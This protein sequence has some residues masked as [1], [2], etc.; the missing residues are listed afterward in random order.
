MRLCSIPYMEV[1]QVDL[2]KG[3]LTGSDL[4]TKSAQFN[5]RS[6]PCAFTQESEVYTMDE[7]FS[8]VQ[9]ELFANISVR[10]GSP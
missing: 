1:L 3:S 7:V 6:K 10:C 2:P 5:S 8:Q 4:K 9:R